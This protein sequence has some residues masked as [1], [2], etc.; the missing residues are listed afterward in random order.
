MATAQAYRHREL[1]VTRN[2]HGTQPSRGISNDRLSYILHC[3][4]ETSS[5][6]D[7]PLDT[8]EEED[9]NA[10]FEV[11]HIS[12]ITTSSE[13]CYLFE[14]SFVLSSY[15]SVFGHANAFYY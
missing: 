2:L 15:V 1:S 4:F 3:P 13:V 9:Q 8:D 5:F 6:G 12:N 7:I 14:H 10:S 11:S